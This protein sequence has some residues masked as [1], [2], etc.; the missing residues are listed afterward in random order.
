MKFHILFA[1]TVFAFSARQL[2]AFSTGGCHGLDRGDACTIFVRHRGGVA[3]RPGT[4]TEQGENLVCV[5]D[6]NY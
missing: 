6:P 4:C 2:Q 5:Q 3:A 1:L